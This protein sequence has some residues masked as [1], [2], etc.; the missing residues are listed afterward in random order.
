[1]LFKSAMP[2]SIDDALSRFGLTQ[3]RP[4]QREIIE[5]VLAG[6]ATIAVLPTGAGKSLCYQLP[7][8][9]LGGLTVVVSPLISLMKDQV[10]ALAARGIP[11]TFINSAVEP[12]EREARLRQA[13][14]GE[15]R[16]LY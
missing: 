11:A 8:V 5:A 2:L 7:A 9:A 14:R 13:V 10:D 16:L 15:L 4:G 12:A 3:F 1:M 6:R